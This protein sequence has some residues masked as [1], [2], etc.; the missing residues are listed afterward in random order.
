[1]LFG[2]LCWSWQ[3][4]LFTLSNLLGAI[5]FLAAFIVLKRYGVTKL[6]L[7][8]NLAL[9]ATVCVG[10]ALLV[11]IANVTCG[12]EELRVP[13]D[14]IAVIASGVALFVF[15]FAA[16]HCDE[17]RFGEQSV[18]NSIRPLIPHLAVSAGAGMACLV[19]V[20]GVAFIGML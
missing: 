10:F 14:I 19:T 5:A 7:A 12:L 20:C 6:R 15:G 2:H 13:G 8:S 17:I 9:F 18:K 4:M 16:L 3:V 11:G 1:M